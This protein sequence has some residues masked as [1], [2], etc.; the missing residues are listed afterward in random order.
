MKALISPVNSGGPVMVGGHC[1]VLHTR[2]VIWAPGAAHQSR[3]KTILE[4][5]TT[6]TLATRDTA[7]PPGAPIRVLEEAPGIHFGVEQTE[8]LM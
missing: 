3:L 5:S 7:G 8:G 2:R 6:R 4:R 1:P